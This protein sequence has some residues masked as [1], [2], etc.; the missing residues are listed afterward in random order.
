[1]VAESR[2]TFDDISIASRQTHVH[3]IAQLQLIRVLFHQSH[4]ILQRTQMC[5]RLILILLY[6]GLFSRLYSTILFVRVRPVTQWLISIIA[7]HV[8]THRLVA[9]QLLVDIHQFRIVAH[10]RHGSGVS[11]RLAV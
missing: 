2:D 6:Y 3:L 9:D 5:Q 4:K 11:T 1:M 10:Q 8:I 7:Q